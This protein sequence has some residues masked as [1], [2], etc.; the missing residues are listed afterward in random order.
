MP[1]CIVQTSEQHRK[2]GI[3]TITIWCN[4]NKNSILSSETRRRQWKVK[5]KPSKKERK[6]PQ[7]FTPF[8]SDSKTFHSK[9]AQTAAVCSHYTDGQ[10][11]DDYY[12]ERNDSLKPLHFFV[13]RLAATGPFLFSAKNLCSMGHCRCV[14][15]GRRSGCRWLFASFN[16]FQ[17]NYK[18]KSCGP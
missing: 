13:W 17:S 11:V 2:T 1:S 6:K 9:F 5:G 10:G 14:V 16:F 12:F 3:A 18:I 4:W 8:P 7:N 15:L